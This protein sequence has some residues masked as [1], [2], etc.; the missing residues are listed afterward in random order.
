MSRRRG[1]VGCVVRKGPSWFVRFWEDVPGQSK[2]KLRSVR[3]CPVSGPGAIKTQSERE[4]RAKQ[5]IQESGVDTEQHFQQVQA[6]NLG[7]TFQQQAEWWLQHVQ[8]RKRK[9]VKPHTVSS[10]KSH[11]KWINPRLGAVPLADV[12]NLALKNLVAEMAAARNDDDTPRFSAK[13]ISN[14]AQVVK[15]VVASAIGDN[16]D[17]LHPRKWNHEFIDLPDVANQRTPTFTPEDVENIISAAEG[18]YR[19]LYA[20]LAATGLRI[21]EA[22]ALEV[23]HVS[24]CHVGITGTLSVCQGLWNGKL[25]S[26]KTRNGYREVDLPAGFV[27]TLQQFIGDRTAGRAAGFVFRTPSGSP[28]HQSNVLRRSLHP[29][30]AK[31]GLEKAGF[32]S[33]RRFRVTHL[34]KANCPEDLLRYW[35]GHGDKTVTDRYAKLEQDVAYR[36]AVVEQM[37][38]GFAP[39][40]PHVPNC[41]PEIEGEEVEQVVVQ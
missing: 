23:R 22:L 5:I 25:Q 34:R 10:W 4:R 21:G 24:Y 13:S 39:I 7:T 3:I 8:T 14:Y 2:R 27:A 28:L 9:P 30:L 15:M 33:F 38:L 40:V 37:G 19:V 26:P 11:L 17:E 32:H 41:S 31:L 18:Q 36:K 6:V 29:I 20:L 1:Q 16:G 35:I 12:N